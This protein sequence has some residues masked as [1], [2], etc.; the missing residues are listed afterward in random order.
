MSKL[1]PSLFHSEEKTTKIHKQL[2]VIEGL[3]DEYNLKNDMLKTNTEYLNCAQENQEECDKIKNILNDKR[4][5][6][7]E[8]EERK[9]DSSAN[10][11]KCVEKQK[12]CKTLLNSVEGKRKEFN[13]LF[14]K[15]NDLEKQINSCNNKKSECDKIDSDIKELEK[16][17]TKYESDLKKLKQKAIDNNCD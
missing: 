12:Q 10:Y 9:K 4:K 5:L 6:L 13:N 11:Q 16:T 1:A 8:T 17:I 3:T 7:N 2:P 14:V 15:I